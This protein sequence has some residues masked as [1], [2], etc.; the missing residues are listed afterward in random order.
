MTNKDDKNQTNSYECYD[1]LA[2]FR[3]SQLMKRQAL[4]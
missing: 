4:P 1:L 2:Q 3:I